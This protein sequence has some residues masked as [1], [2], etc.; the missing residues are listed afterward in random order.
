MQYTITVKENDKLVVLSESYIAL[1]AEDSDTQ[2]WAERA[3]ELCLN[4]SVSETYL[5]GDNKLVA[6]VVKI[7]NK[8]TVWSKVELPAVSSQWGVYTI[9]KIIS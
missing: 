4:F 8:A 1:P 6:H 9:E 5:V 7:D 3:I 2:D